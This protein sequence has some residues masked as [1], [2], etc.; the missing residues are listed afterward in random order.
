[1]IWYIGGM[2]IFVLL[3]LKASIGSGDRSG[4]YVLQLEMYAMLWWVTHQ[5]KEMVDS[6][7]VWYLGVLRLNQ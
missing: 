2:V 6:L 3:M 1:M 7:E 4:D 5:K